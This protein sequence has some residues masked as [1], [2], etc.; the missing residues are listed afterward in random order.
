MLLRG[1][2]PPQKA[3]Q[4]ARGL[5]NRGLIRD[6]GPG[7]RKKKFVRKTLYI[8]Q[9]TLY[10]AEEPKDPQKIKKTKHM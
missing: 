8:L 7:S 3:L 5:I 1:Q 6:T 2:S 10:V 4:K 9:K